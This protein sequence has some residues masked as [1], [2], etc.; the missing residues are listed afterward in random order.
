MS[1]DLARARARVAAGEWLA[2]Y[3]GVQDPKTMRFSC[4]ELLTAFEEGYAE[5]I[6]DDIMDGSELTLTARV[7]DAA[8][9]GNPFTMSDI[10][11]AATA[12]WAARD[13]IDRL[14]AGQQMMVD[15]HTITV[16]TGQRQLDD[17]TALMTEAAKQF[18]IYEQ[19]H[20]DK[21]E[22]L[23]MQTPVDPVQA[24]NMIEDTKRKAGVNAFIAARLEAWLR[25]DDQYPVSVSHD[26]P[27]G[28]TMHVQAPHLSAQIGDRTRDDCQPK[29]DIIADYTGEPSIGSVPDRVVAI[30]EIIPA[31]G[32]RPDDAHPG[33][34]EGGFVK[35]MSPVDVPAVLTAGDWPS[36]N[37]AR[38]AA[39]IAER[40][41]NGD[42]I[43][44][45]DL[46]T[47]ER[48]G[49]W[50]D[51]PVEISAINGPPMRDPELVSKIW[52]DAVAEQEAPTLAE[53]RA[54]ACAAS[55]FI[56]WAGGDGPPDDWDKGEVL[57]DWGKLSGRSDRGDPRFTICP[58]MELHPE[59]GL[60][61]AD[62]DPT[63]YATI[64]GYRS[65][66]AKAATPVARVAAEPS[67]IAALIQARNWLMSA[68][69]LIAAAAEHIRG[70]TGA[71]P[72]SD[73]ADLCARLDAW[74]C[75]L[76][77]RPADEGAEKEARRTSTTH[78][79]E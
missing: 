71:L 65:T 79:G 60:W 75:P 22:S 19:H 5:R 3:C 28:M 33:F 39:Q 21:V 34:A 30:R 67:P 53:E 29:G 9:R 10:T 20:T 13:R 25:G 4:A 24:T 68:E 78:Q 44:G 48:A 73:S 77:T 45:V 51:Q 49:E 74:L 47:F 72:G 76:A 31:V 17:A 16:A 37:P 55:G 63:S 54:T 12:M 50:M 69:Q 64:I 56:P 59:P 36:P 52:A 40:M 7:L 27:D 57:L 43:V 26:H 8:T 6:H 15:E 66:I 11:R 14:I 2:R 70:V 1:D 42:T 35:E 41:V 32:E 18:R 61:A 62:R 38:V 23:M 46:E 58:S